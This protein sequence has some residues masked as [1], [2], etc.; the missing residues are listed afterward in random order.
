MTNVCGIAPESALRRYGFDFDEFVLRSAPLAERIRPL[1][2]R[3]RW[4][5]TGPVGFSF[6]A[7]APGWSTVYP[8]G[9]AL[10]FADPFT[11]TGI[12]NALI[13]GRLAGAAAAR[14]VASSVHMAQC[15]AALWR[16]FFAAS[17]LRRL[18]ALPSWLAALVP[19][20][21]LF[22]MTRAV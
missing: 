7:S 14:G 22:R 6:P 1:R 20:E 8:A 13:T 19:G 4:L 17:V 11:G 5:V 16:P 9:D 2:R 21:V 18:T 15:R 3:M 12:L 10:G